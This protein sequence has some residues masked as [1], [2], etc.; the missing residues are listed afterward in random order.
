MH[1][2][3]QHRITFRRCDVEKCTPL[4]R[5]AQFRVKM[6]K[7][8]ELR[9][10]LRSYDVEKCMPL[11]REAHVQVKMEVS[12]NRGT[13]KSSILVGF[14]ITNQAFWGTTIYGKP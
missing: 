14:S 10:T 1:K 3:Q 8:L 11:W 5:E 2:T 6:Y 13:P 4:W 12:Q 9:S 7:A